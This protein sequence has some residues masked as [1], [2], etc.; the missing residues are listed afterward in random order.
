[1]LIPVLE[2]EC[3]PSHESGHP[4]TSCLSPNPLL[5][6]VLRAPV[7][8]VP[9]ELYDESCLSPILYRPLGYEIRAWNL[10]KADLFARGC[11]AKN[12]HNLAF[13]LLLF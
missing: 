5:P 13:L 6:P 7:C 9:S 4:G 8:E 2:F 3:V 12:G 10:R 11:T 1:M